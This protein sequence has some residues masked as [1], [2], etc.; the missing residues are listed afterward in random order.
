VISISSNGPYHAATFST[1]AVRKHTC[2]HTLGW[3]LFRP[4]KSVSSR[5]KSVNSIFSQANMELL[6]DQDAF[7]AAHGSKVLD[8]QTLNANII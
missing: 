5:N 4:T 2:I 7:D 3:L 8:N 1:L 6:H